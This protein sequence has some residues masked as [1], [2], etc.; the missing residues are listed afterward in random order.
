MK[1]QLLFIL[2]LTG[3]L[4]TACDTNDNSANVQQSDLNNETASNLSA[5]QKYALAYMWNE[6]KLAYDIYLAL[7]EINPARQFVNIATKSETTHIELVENLIKN[8]DINISNLKDYTV[9]YS[10][11]ELRAL[12]AGKYGVPEIQ[13]LYNVLYEKGTASLASA[14]E[15]GCMVEVTDVDDLDKYILLSNDNQDLLDTFNILRDGSYK[16]YWAFDSGLKNIGVT[17]GCC[18]LGEMYCKTT[19]EYPQ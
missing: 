6:E 8:Y 2:M 16:H 4:L 1:K 9:N 13:E 19:E 3:L 18:S 14:F 15:V 5:E 7:N 11:E 10:Q 12:P 17:D